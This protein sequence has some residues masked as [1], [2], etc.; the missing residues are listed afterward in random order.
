MQLLSLIFLT[1]AGTT[2]SKGCQS[3][4]A[5]S[6]TTI[7]RPSHEPSTDKIERVSSSIARVPSLRGTRPETPTDI[8]E[9]DEEVVPLQAWDQYADQLA[10]SSIQRHRMLRR[11]KEDR[12]D[13]GDKKLGLAIRVWLIIAAGVLVTLLCTCNWFICCYCCRKER[14]GEDD[15]D[16]DDEDDMDTSDVELAE[17]SD[18]YLKKKNKNSKKK[19]A[20]V[21]TEQPT[22]QE[23]RDSKVGKKAWTSPFTDR[24]VACV[25]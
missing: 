11:I 22:I 1:F 10:A 9:M 12:I 15:E 3:V 19:T 21:D 18:T 14:N 4:P 6:S 2:L 20:P 8:L 25:Y 17:P 24:D 5:V 7:H 16:D 13:L 23:E